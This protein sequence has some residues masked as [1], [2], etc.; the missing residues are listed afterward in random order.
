MIAIESRKDA[1]DLGLQWLAANRRARRKGM[2]PVLALRSEGLPG[3]LLV[4]H[5]FD[6][7][8]VAAA[9]PQSPVR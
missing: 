7:A 4:V 8:A 1:S 5:E 6:L 9:S 2:L 3:R